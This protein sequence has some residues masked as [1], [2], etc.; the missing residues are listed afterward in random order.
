MMAAVVSEWEKGH[1]QLIADGE[2]AMNDYLRKYGTFE[3]RRL[4]ITKEYGEKIAKAAT[5]GEKLTLSKEM[6]QELNALDRRMGQSQK[7]WTVLMGNLGGLSRQMLEDY[8]A[9]AEALVRESE[10]SASEETKNMVNAIE[11]AR[12]ILAKKNP[13]TEMHDALKKYKKALREGNAEDAQKYWDEFSA[14]VEAV[15][16]TVNDITNTLGNMGGLVSA[17]LEKAIGTVGAV[18]DGVAGAIKA[19]GN[20]SATAGDKIKGISGIISAVTTIIGDLANA[21]EEP[22]R[23]AR[24]FAMYQERFANAYFLSMQKIKDADYDSIFGTNSIQ[25][26]VDAYSNM[27]EVQQR[28]NESL[29]KT[30]DAA[31][32]NSASMDMWGKELATQNKKRR[33]ALQKGYDEIQSMTLL[34]S[35]ANFWQKL[36]GKESRYTTLKDVAPELWDDNGAFNVEAAKIFL[37]TSETINKANNAAQ[38]ETLENIIRLKEADEELIALIDS[39]LSSV[40]GHLSGDITDALFDSIRSGADAW[41][42]FEDAGLKVIDA[43]GKALVK[44]MYIQSYLDT[45]RDRMRAAYETGDSEQTQKELAQIMTDIYSG[46]KTVITGA[47]QAA[48]DWDAMAGNQGWDM[49]KLA[50]AGKEASENTLRGEYAK[51]SQKSIDLLAGQTGALR[52]AVERILAWMLARPDV[53]EALITQLT[54]SLPYISDM[55]AQSLIEMRGIR[56]LTAI[57]KDSNQ[58]IAENTGKTNELLSENKEA[59]AAVEAAVASVETAVVKE[60]AGV[61]AATGKTT[62]A[63]SNIDRNGLK[64]KTGGL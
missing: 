50:N 42:L 44:E 55:I 11:K 40:F 12:Q 6:K 46:L 26:A 41:E 13:F 47:E 52:V 8:I 21:F 57:I 5:E 23:A 32:H 30:G 4:A 63:L 2:K 59:V 34:V 38:K 9:K 33:E 3:E 49:S 27:M 15:K 24:E 56:E 22:G 1:A 36:V 51:A 43:L 7:V 48:R 53:N 60:V 28:Y 10:D 45:F 31:R 14:A 18:V 37:E 16:S 35:E 61:T 64:I 29:N 54:G 58:K 20:D 25:K 62:E 17:D 19:F 39:Q